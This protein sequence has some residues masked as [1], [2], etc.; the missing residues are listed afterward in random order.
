MSGTT[1]AFSR[2]RVDVTLGGADIGITE[3]AAHGVE[4]EAAHHRATRKPV[5]YGGKFSLGREGGSMVVQTCP[6]AFLR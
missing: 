3:Q 1:K 2:V 4:V 6:A 5:A